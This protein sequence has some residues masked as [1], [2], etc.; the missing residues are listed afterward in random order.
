MN[1]DVVR[2]EKNGQIC[3]LILNRPD[4]LNSINIDMLEQMNAAVKMV[5]EDRDIRVVILTGEGRGFCSGADMEFVTY[6]LALKGPQFRR[7]LRDVVHRAVNS[8]EQLE[9]PVIAAVNG[10]ATGGGAEIALA[11]DFRIAS[12]KAIFAFTE[13]K[14]GII[15]DGGGIPR[16]AR[17]VG[18]GKAKELIMIGRKVDGS[19]AERIG[20]VN[21]CVSHDHLMA[22]AR[23]WAEELINC[24]PLAIGISKRIIDQA[25]DVDIATALDM[26]GFAQQE[27]LASEDLK[28]GVDAFLEKR[29]PVFKGC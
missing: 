5:G 23:Q 25:M 29:K 8:L 20:L 12:E 7:V 11:C 22:E 1:Y 27:L 15:P 13:V 18:I 21:K 24:A 28:E 9:K 14:V 19:E 6:L 4:H 26:T 10:Y 17:L 16:L 2:V 3:T